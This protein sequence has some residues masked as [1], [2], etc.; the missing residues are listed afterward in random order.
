MW[1]ENERFLAPRPDPGQDHGWRYI[2]RRGRRLLDEGVDPSTFRAGKY[3]PEGSLHPTLAVNA[4]P[5][6]V[7]GAYDT[8][9]FEAMKAVEIEVRRAVERVEAAQSDGV[10][11]MHQAFREG[12]P[13]WDSSLP[14]GEQKNMPL[15]FAGAMGVFRNAA[16]HRELGIESATEVAGEIRFADVLL[17]IVERTEGP[18]PA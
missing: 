13:L 6:Y 2:T 12:G 17:A 18:S 9:I 7:R 16:A 15:L 4:R 11:L 5:P 3:L 14:S 1:L 10:R 8:A